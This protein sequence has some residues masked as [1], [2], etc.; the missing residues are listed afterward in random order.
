MVDISNQTLATLLVAAIVI[1]LGGTII[2]LN[3]LGG[4]MPLTGHATSSMANITVTGAADIDVTNNIDLGTG[5][6]NTSG[7]L[8]N[9]S[10]NFT[11]N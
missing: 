3:R 5:T 11:T 6:A 7:D 1:S 2:S 10:S 9:V 8:F 4:I